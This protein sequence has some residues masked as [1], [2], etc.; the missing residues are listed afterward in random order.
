MKCVDD[1]NTFFTLNVLD[2][3]SDDEEIAGYISELSVLGKSYRDIHTDL[4]NGLDGAAYEAQYPTQKKFRDDVN[5]K[6]QNAKRKL[7]TAKR[8]KAN[9]KITDKES[10]LLSEKINKLRTI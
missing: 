1:I 5:T 3:M 10:E 4:S 8:G 7:R 6:I 2:E 9:T